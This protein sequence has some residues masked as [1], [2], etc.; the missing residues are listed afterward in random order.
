MKSLFKLLWMFLFFVFI[1]IT[2]NAQS[3]DDQAKVLQKC[4]DLAELQQYYPLDD[5][6]KP[7]QLHVMNY[8]VTFPTDL[9]VAKSGQQ[10]L[11]M[12]REEILQQKITSYFIFRSFD[13][14]DNSAKAVFSYFYAFDYTN[15]QFKMLIVNIDLEKVNQDW[16][17]INIKLGGDTK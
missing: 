10:V 5:A 9:N 17:V 1:Q 6:G 12:P 3:I 2:G 14:T 7:V 4:I 11:F 8:A 13:I 15:N 16:S